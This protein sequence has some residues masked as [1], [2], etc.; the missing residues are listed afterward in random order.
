MRTYCSDKK[1]FEIINLLQYIWICNKGQCWIYFPQKVWGYV[2]HY[3]DQYLTVPGFIHNNPLPSNITI[4]NHYSWSYSH[5]LP[6]TNWEYLHHPPQNLNLTCYSFEP[7]HSNYN[8]LWHL[9]LVMF[10][11]YYFSSINSP[12]IFTL[13]KYPRK[14][15]QSSATHH[16][17]STPI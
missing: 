8:C 4:Y 14:K 15:Y 5:L 16:G 13:G 17:A 6:N 7:H 9:Q 1:V 10:Y 11:H 12:C 2:E 3:N